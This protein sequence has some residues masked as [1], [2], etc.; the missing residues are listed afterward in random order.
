MDSSASASSTKVADYLSANGFSAQ[1]LVRSPYEGIVN[2]V[3]LT[4]DVALRINKDRSL[5]CDLWTETVAVDPAVAA[6]VQ[7][8]PLLLF[9]NSLDPIPEIVTVYQRAP[10]KPLAFTEELDA[11]Q[12]YFELGQQLA[13]LHAVPEV[14][15]PHRF[16][17]SAW[18]LEFEKIRA[19]APRTPEKLPPETKTVFCH[20]DLHPENLLVHEGRFSAVLDWGDAGFGPPATDFRYVPPRYLEHALQGYGQDSPELRLWIA[21]HVIDQWLY[22]TENGRTYG[23]FGDTT[24]DEIAAILL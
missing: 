21:W 8:P 10:G 3:W 4:D 12:F 16:L 9:D 19:K 20:Q 15:D 24:W 17:D 5:T 7:T 6:G 13:M 11:E 2:E 18:E 22:V 1:G 23:K 14:A